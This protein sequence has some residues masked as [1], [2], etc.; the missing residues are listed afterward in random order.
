MTSSLG[1]LE[2]YQR[3]VAS[4]DTTV[5]QIK[6]EH[7]H[8]ATPCTEWDA[9]QLVNHIVGE[10]LWLPP[11]M[12]GQTIEDVGSRFDGD[13]LGTDPVGVWAT[14]SKEALAAA[15]APGALDRTVQLSF[16]ETP[17]SEYVWQV[18]ADHAIHAWDLAVAIGAD[19]HMD[20]GV[21]DALSTWFAGNEAG[22]RAG[23]VIGERPE[24]SPDAG[25]Q[26]QLL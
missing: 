25:P 24:L 5:H 23:G 13:L 1:P 19:Q 14:A 22:Y 16:G 4:F 9:R 12:H 8:S 17:A 3:A 20:P 18:A 10:D 7:W 6:D 2:V 11:L 21:V 15:E 26:S